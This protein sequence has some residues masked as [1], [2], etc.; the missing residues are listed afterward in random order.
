MYTWGFIISLGLSSVAMNTSPISA[1]TITLQNKVF[2]LDAHVF[3]YG[4][5][6][7]DIRID[8][9][10]P[11]D[12]ATLDINT[13]SVVASGHIPA[14][15]MAIDPSSTGSEFSD[16]TRNIKA[17]SVDP[18][19]PNV[20]NIAL[21]YGP[22]VVSAATLTYVSPAGR[23][24]DLDLKYEVI[25]NSDY[26][27]KDGSFVDT[28]STYQ[29][30]VIKDNEVDKFSPEVSTS[31]MH[32]QFYKPVADNAKHP[33]VIWFHGNGEGGIPGYINNKSQLL[34]NRGG[35]A[36]V[37]DEAQSTLDKPYVVAPQ[38]DDTWYYN[39]SKDYITKMSETIKEIIAAN[40]DIDKNR[41][42]VA[43][44][45]AGGYMTWH[46]L[47]NNPNMFAAANIIC[48]AIDVAPSR[49]GVETTAAQIESVK[50]IPIWLVQSADDPVIRV[51]LSSRFAYNILKDSGAIYTEYP[52]VI[53][54]GISYNG[55]FSWVYAAR[56]MPVHNGQ[57]L[58]SWLGEQ[59]LPAETLQGAIENIKVEGFDW[60][61]VVTK[62]IIRLQAPIESVDV[63]KLQLIERKPDMFGEV[64]TTERI[65]EKA[66]VSDANGNPVSGE[67]NYMTLE[68][69][70]HPD[71]GISPFTFLLSSF[72]NVWSN[73]FE[74]Q[75]NLK[76]GEEL[77][78]KDKRYNEL[79]IHPVSEHMIKPLTDQ[80]TKHTFT[81]ASK[82]I[83]L[84]YGSYQ[85][86]NP[87]SEKKPL[88]IW[89]HGAG[90]GGTD[91]DIIALGNRATRLVDT[92]IQSIMDGAYVLMPQSPTMWMDDGSGNYTS[93]GTSK[94]TE[95][96]MSLIKDY[97]AKNPNVDTDRIYIG[98]DSNGGFMTM[99]MII[100]YPTYFAAA[101]PICEAYADAWITDSMIQSIKDIPI[102]FTHSKDDPVVAVDQHSIPTYQRLLNANAKD[103]RLTLY[104]HVIDTSGKYKQEDGSPYMYNGHW[105]WIYTLNNEVQKDGETIF[106]WLSKQKL[107]SK[108]EEK[109][110]DKAGSNTGDSTNLPLYYGLALLSF[111]YITFRNIKKRR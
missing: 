19:N 26:L 9:G 98:G 111:T 83:T 95:T 97:V 35:V 28:A 49:G 71:T 62:V 110:D 85:P 76:V 39:Y 50:H 91:P 58:W 67:S 84:S 11:V 92:E 44:A 53:A 68:P 2:E 75:V 24:V 61:P 70:V 5:N 78:G 82:N 36:F 22:T 64:Q 56:N 1:Q 103:V 105:S 40:P 88:M 33:L 60:G 13:F 107:T 73:P 27:L 6:I 8:V 38:V 20:I 80:I 90:E 10:S 55:H 29:M 100:H 15:V 45:S 108:A 101:Y 51:D 57:S 42:Y 94:Y 32:Y 23:N 89:L 3:D 69:K 66:Y 16:V 93:D 72:L 46:M 99:N 41:I 48:V 52:N 106:V 54:D 47:I 104:D 81:D 65:I 14:A 87:T 59:T 31:G 18:L 63:N 43:G 12:P 25:Q 4:Q 77:T 17:V 102:W 21:E 37:S 30:G 96:L 86:V 79:A 34:A 7:T 74:L 109:K